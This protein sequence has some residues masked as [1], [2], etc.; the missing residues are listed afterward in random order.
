M[1]LLEASQDLALQETIAVD[2]INTVEKI[3]TALTSRI[4]AKISVLFEK[5]NSGIQDLGYRI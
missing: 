4:I 3:N 2:E 5:S 1:T